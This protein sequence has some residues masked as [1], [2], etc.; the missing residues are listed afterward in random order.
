MGWPE[1]ASPWGGGGEAAAAVATARAGAA[2]PARTAAPMPCRIGLGADQGCRS[3]RWGA[4]E[5]AGVSSRCRTH[6]G[7]FVQT[8]RARKAE[9]ADESVAGRAKKQKR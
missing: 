3:L 5:A 6:A 9:C 7:K 4:G 1:L 2:S 8:N